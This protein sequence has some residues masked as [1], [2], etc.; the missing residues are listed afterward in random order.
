[1]RVYVSVRYY[2][3]S[4]FGNNYYSVNPFTFFTH[5]RQSTF[6]AFC[7]CRL[8]FGVR[9]SSVRPY[10]Y[11]SYRNTFTVNPGLALRCG[12]RFRIGRLRFSDFRFGRGRASRVADGLRNDR[13]AIISNH[14][15]HIM[16]AANGTG[17]NHPNHNN[18]DLEE[19]LVK[20]QSECTGLTRF[21]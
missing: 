16:S 3:F 9:V 10:S 17:R 14:I 11:E 6:C 20:T 12:R 8:S 2:Y 13:T 1:M 4:P 5:F 15:P 18:C 7:C 19:Q 21:G